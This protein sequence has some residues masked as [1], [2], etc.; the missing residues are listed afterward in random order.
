MR[1]APAPYFDRV[2]CSACCVTPAAWSSRERQPVLLRGHGSRALR[3]RP[4][5]LS[6]VARKRV[7]ASR[8]LCRLLLGCGRC[9]AKGPE[10][11]RQAAEGAK[12]SVQT[13]ELR[14]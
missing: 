12:Y 5:D 14:I 2:C 10:A 9:I 11:A 8:H 3:H 13:R 6:R 4:A 1:L 7:I